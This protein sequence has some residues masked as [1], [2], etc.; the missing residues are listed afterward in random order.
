M[1]PL[2]ERTKAIAHGALLLASMG[3]GNGIAMSPA[4]ADHGFTPDPS[5]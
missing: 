1:S 2:T 4:T 3:I 5:A